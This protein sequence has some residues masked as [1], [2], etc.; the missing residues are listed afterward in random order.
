MRIEK[1]S[2]FALK[3]PLHRPYR[4]SGGRLEFTG[5]DST[6]VRLV[7]LHRDFDRIY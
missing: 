7:P 4:L 2:V 1:V 6:F 3:M 5:I